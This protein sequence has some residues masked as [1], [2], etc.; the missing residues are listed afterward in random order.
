MASY[1][2][3]PTVDS[4]ANEFLLAGDKGAAAILGATAI[5]YRHSQIELG[6]H[7]TPKLA[8]AGKS[9]GQA[10]LESVNE[11][12]IPYPNYKEIIL[13]WTILGDPALVIQP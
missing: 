9:I 13:G 11:I 12:K 2:V 10:L 7:L 4:L 1:F 8:Q 3:D 5:S 6:N